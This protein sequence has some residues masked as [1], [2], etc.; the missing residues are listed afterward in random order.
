MALKEINRTASNPEYISNIIKDTPLI[1]SVIVCV[2]DD[3][4]AVAQKASSVVVLIGKTKEGLKRLMSPEIRHI[5][6]QTISI[7]DIVRYRIYEVRNSF[8][9]KLLV[10]VTLLNLLF[11]RF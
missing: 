4:L 8:H 9:T 11:S 7:S 5:I 2:G 3:N 1:K 6:S 10:V